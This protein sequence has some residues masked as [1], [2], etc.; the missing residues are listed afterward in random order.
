MQG[1]YGGMLETKHEILRSFIRGRLPAS[2][3]QRSLTHHREACV[4]RA[5]GDAPILSV[6]H[7]ASRRPSCPG[8]D[9]DWWQIHTREERLERLKGLLS[10]SGSYL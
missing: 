2:H 9:L 1:G 4:P 7:V 10:I 8:K 5:V 6:G 3:I